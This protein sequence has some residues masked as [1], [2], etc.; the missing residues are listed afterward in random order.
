MEL[1]YAFAQH[2]RLNVAI[3]QAYFDIKLQNRLNSAELAK[4]AM[5]ITTAAVTS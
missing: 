2:H 3:D 4:V 5:R 1:M